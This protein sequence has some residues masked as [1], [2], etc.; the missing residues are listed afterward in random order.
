MTRH[1]RPMLAVLLGLAGAT[2][3]AADGPGLARPRNVAAG[4]APA[5]T[6]AATPNALKSLHPHFALLDV[7]G[8]NVLAS[9]RAVST[10]KSCGQCHDAGYIASHAFHADLGLRSFAPSGNSWHASAGLFGHWDPLRYR[11]LS[12]A[13]DERLD[14]STAGWLMA[15]GE[16]VVGGGPATT[17]RRGPALA[18]LEPRADD[19]ETALLQPDGSRR[20]WDWN[21]SGT[22]EMNCF[23]C[24]LDKPD[25]DARAAAIREGR[26]GDANTATLS[27]LGIVEAGAGRWRW[28]R[29]AFT[30][31]GLLDSRR[32]SIQDPTN[33]NCAACHGQVHA[34]G[35]APLQVQACDTRQ[36]QT[37]TTGQVVASQR[38]GAS[39][40]NLAQK[41][42]LTRS[43]DIHAERLLQCTDCHH[44]LNNPAHGRARGDQPAHLRYDPRTL[45]I[46]P[47]LQRPDH[48]LARGASAA[49]RAQTPGQG[50]MRRCE[51]CHDATT[52][53]AHWLPYVDTHMATLACESCHIPKL[54]APAIESIDWTVL[55]ADGGPVQTCRGVAGDPADVRALVTGYEPVLIR[56]R[57]PGG[58]GML[59]PY[60][61]VTSFYW[62]Y[63]DAQ[64]RKRPVRLADLRAAYLDGATHAA[65]IVAAFDADHDGRIGAEE[66]R[67]D[68]PRKEAAVQARLQALGLNQVRMEGQVQPF[69]VHHSVTRG[70]FA[71]NRCQDCHAASSRVNQGL[72]LAGFAPVTPVLAAGRSIAATGDVVR[73][74]DGA[75][76]YQPAPARDAL[77]V[78]GATRVSLVD[79]LGAMAL[80]GTVLG[81]AGHGAL[82]Y[83]AYRRRPQVPAHTH[84]VRMYDAYRRFWHWLQAFSI[85]LL[86]LTG[87]VIHRPELFGALSFSGVVA[88]HNVLAAV[89][90]V[91]AALSLFY[92]LATERLREYLPNPHGFFDDSIRQARYYLSG[93]FKGE[94]HPFEKRPDDRMN[95]IQ[96]LTYFGILN[97]LLPAQIVT[98]ALMWGVQRWPEAAVALGGLP[99]LAPAHTLLAWLF[100]CFIVGHVYLTTTGPTPLEAIRGMVTGDEDVEVHDVAPAP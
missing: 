46:G 29:A 43:W 89:L 100:A 58:D 71:L 44:A 59:S 7:Y 17:S 93:I 47:Y 60:N 55:M 41:A 82:R 30:P 40:V 61:L 87:L 85:V 27:G 37:A 13:G 96:K 70:E 34:A 2:T 24:H 1:I 78:F 12:Q 53:H 73:R 9:G 5:P 49:S 39:G 56:R 16:R 11:Y 97:V 6:A 22:M 23:L 50:A 66:L 69:A 3:W 79:A 31:D 52:S 28:N 21:L 74:A 36:P 54:H 32:L 75:L 20:A 76:F 92:H 45:E 95:P 33:A 67:I 68:T 83:R 14:L 19:P 91:N 72:Q 35:S 57:Q 98:G 62:V 38:I 84:K 48:D 77:Y 99:V 25:L 65:D 18:H 8:V 88:L 94:A 15:Y 10:M 81:V 26:F 90:V 51:D 63:Q 42:T 64:G 86:L 4:P 80:I